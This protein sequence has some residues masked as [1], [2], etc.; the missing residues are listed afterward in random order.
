VIDDVQHELTQD[1]RALIRAHPSYN[2][3]LAPTSRAQRTWNIW[4]IAALWVGM[5]VCIPTYTLAADLIKHGMNWWQAN[6][7][8]A[9][10]NLI[11]LCSLCRARH[12]AHY[13][14]HRIM[15]RSAQ[16]Q[17]FPAG[18]AIDTRHNQSASRNASRASGGR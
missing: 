16:E 12:N 14:A 4:H 3:D 11:V 7:T 9:L 10:G 18:S 17:P 2:D 15:P 6:L 13:A 5:A 8:V 1:E